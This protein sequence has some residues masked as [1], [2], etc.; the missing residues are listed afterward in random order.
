M[1]DQIETKEIECGHVS[2]IVWNLKE[3]CDPKMTIAQFKKIVSYIFK[4]TDEDKDSLIEDLNNRLDENMLI[5]YHTN[6]KTAYNNLS[7]K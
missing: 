3:L 7:K 1:M 4:H 5:A 2:H 6:K